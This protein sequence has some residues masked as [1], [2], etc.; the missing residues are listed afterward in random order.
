MSLVNLSKFVV[1]GSNDPDFGGEWLGWKKIKQRTCKI[2]TDSRLLTMRFL[3]SLLTPQCWLFP[4]F[5]A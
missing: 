2:S 3:A 1:F 5:G 4:F